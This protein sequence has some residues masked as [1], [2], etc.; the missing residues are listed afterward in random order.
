MPNGAGTSEPSLRASRLIAEA[1]VQRHGPWRIAR[2]AARFGIC[3]ALTRAMLAACGQTA[4]DP[5]TAARRDV[6]G[7]A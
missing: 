2:R 1:L 3:P 5:L 4:V 7:P 6:P